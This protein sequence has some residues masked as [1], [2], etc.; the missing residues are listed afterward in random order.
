ME[1]LMATTEQIAV[2]A[3]Q[4][5]EKVAETIVSN[6]AAVQA[7]NSNAYI[8]TLFGYQFNLMTILILGI[9]VGV[10]YM[11]YQIQT[12]ERLDF[13]DMFTKDGRKVSSTKVLQFLAGIASTWFIVKQGLAGTLTEGIFGIYLAYM[14][15]IEGFSKFISAKYNYNETAIKDASATSL[16]DGPITQ[17]NV[18]AQVEDGEIKTIEQTT[19]QKG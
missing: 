1:S 14:G 18:S 8:L 4:A 16:S 2:Q 6:A 5:A 19:I 9:I 15:S 11:F 7:I 3:A 12:S 10:L 13:A 17:T